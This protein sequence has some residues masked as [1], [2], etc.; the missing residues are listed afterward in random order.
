[1]DTSGLTETL[2]FEPVWINVMD[3]FPKQLKRATPFLS[4]L[5]C[6][7]ISRQR[8][9]WLDGITDSVD[10]SL[11]KLWELMKTGKPGALQFMGSQ[12]V[13]HDSVTEQQERH[14]LEA[15]WSIAA[16]INPFFGL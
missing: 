3:S 1:M 9:R 12:R 6:E 10:M 5:F 13:G 2:L 11:S 7:F 8:M 16:S 14:I 4:I 15:A